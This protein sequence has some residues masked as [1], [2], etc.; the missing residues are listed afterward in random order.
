[1]AVSEE[2]RSS[3]KSQPSSSSSCADQHYLARINTT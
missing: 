1:M 2:K 3:S